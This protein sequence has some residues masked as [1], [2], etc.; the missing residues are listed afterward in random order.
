[1]DAVS[2]LASAFVLSFW[3]FKSDESI[4]NENLVLALLS[5][6]NEGLLI[7]QQ[8]AVLFVPRYEGQ[9]LSYKS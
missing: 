3:R 5:L 7:L 4:L 6:V 2:T 8:A 9:C 1:M